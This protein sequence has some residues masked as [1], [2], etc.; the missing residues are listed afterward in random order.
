MIKSQKWLRHLN[1][2]CYKNCQ[3]RGNTWSR[4]L[5]RWLALLS[6]LL[7]HTLNCS[8]HQLQ[9]CLW[10][11]FQTKTRVATLT[12][13]SEVPMT[14]LL[15][16]P[17]S[18]TTSSSSLRLVRNSY[19]RRSISSTRCHLSSL[20]SRSNQHHRSTR[21]SSTTYPL[22]SRCH[23]RQYIRRR[24][25]QQQAMEE[26]ILMTSHMIQSSTL[27]KPLLMYLSNNLWKL[28]LSNRLQGHLL[29]LCK[30]NWDKEWF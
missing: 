27:L 26:A 22:G 14:I 19:H 7:W 20:S 30:R 17:P 2:Q 29:K 21:K 5:D 28:C 24:S 1:R 10:A 9:S 18:M 8:S 13:A 23:P 25:I 11:Q 6:Y 16:Q 12:M 4:R 15:L 3:V